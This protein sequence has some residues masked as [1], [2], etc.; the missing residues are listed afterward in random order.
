MSRTIRRNKFNS[1]KSF[2]QHYWECFSKK[3]VEESCL[4]TWKYH[5]DNYYTKRAKSNKQYFKTLMDKKIRREFK[6]KLN[7]INYSNKFKDDFDI[8]L[9]THAKQCINWMIH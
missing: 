9:S 6:I 4:E 8:V 2:F 3:E 1:K 7:K 5:S